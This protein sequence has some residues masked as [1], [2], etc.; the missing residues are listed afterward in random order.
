MAGYHNKY[1][2][3]GVFG[4][5]SKVSEEWQELLDAREQSNPIMEL[6]EISDLVGALESYVK[7]KHNITLEEILRMKD[8][9]KRAF[10]NGH[11]KN[12]KEN[13]E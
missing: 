9:T 7:K 1:I 8:A 10:E 4:E 12:L 6:C 3:K 13:E 11:R 2:A 5:F